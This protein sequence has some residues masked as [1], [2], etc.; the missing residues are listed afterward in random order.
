MPGSGAFGK[1]VFMHTAIE[2]SILYLGT[3]VVLV[4]TRN[5]DS[6]INVAP[7]SSTW[8]LGWNCMLGIASSSKTAENLLRER[9]CVLNFP[10][11]AQAD[12]VNRLAK[13]TG[14]SPVPSSKLA[15]GYQ[16]LKNKL[17]EAGLTA[18]LSDRVRAPRIAECPLHMEA[19]L[20]AAHPFGGFEAQ[21]SFG[22]DL[23]TSRV[24]ALELRIVRVHAEQELLLAGK[25]NH[26]DPDKWR[27]LIMS[28]ARFYGLEGKQLLPSR[29]AE[30]PEELYR[31][32]AHME[33]VRR[34]SQAEPVSA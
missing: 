20:Q 34:L 14:T 11:S 17:G 9:E 19:V 25:A 5:D 23:G 30:I 3:P 18:L 29:L 22:D 21:R 8:F 4:S 6:S 16:H 2:P 13:T 7:M 33:D 31:P 27:P 10:S 24:M 32:A 1:T 28:F 26:I 15:K 12:V